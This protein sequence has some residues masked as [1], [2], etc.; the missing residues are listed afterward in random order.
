MNTHLD[1]PPLAIV[2][3][4][5]FTMIFESNDIKLDENMR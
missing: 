1:F 3:N 5:R 4:Q 2:N